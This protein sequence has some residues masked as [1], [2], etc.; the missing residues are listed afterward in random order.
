ML[1]TVL[2]GVQVL[3]CASTRF[4]GAWGDLDAVCARRE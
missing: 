2:D 4:A 1:R 3:R